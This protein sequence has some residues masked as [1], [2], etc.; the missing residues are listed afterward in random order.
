MLETHLPGV[1]RPNAEA[2][3]GSHP[4]L[5]L[6]A[7]SRLWLEHGTERLAVRPVRCFPWSSPGT[8]VSLRDDD[9][10]ELFLVETLD[11]LDAAS[12]TALGEAMQSAGFVLVINAIDSIEEDYEVRV[13]RTHTR[14]GKRTFQTRLDEW[15][16]EA[17]DGGYLIRDLCGDLFRLPPLET[18]D[19][20]SRHLLWAYVG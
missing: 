3:A 1:A 10:R 12:A 9:D 15:P 8:L 6:G 18:L 7:G 19:P 2:L 20:K 14:H 13:W 4:R 5:W 17:P 16:W 11:V